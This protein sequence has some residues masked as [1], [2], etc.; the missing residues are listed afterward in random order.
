MSRKKNLS[1]MFNDTQGKKVQN[2]MKS[3]TRDWKT[4]LKKKTA[5]ILYSNKMGYKVQPRL[6]ATMIAIWPSADQK[7]NVH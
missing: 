2:K 3:N 1:S 7:K 6:F 5:I 4:L